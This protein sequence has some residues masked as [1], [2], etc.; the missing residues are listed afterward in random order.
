[1]KP[2]SPGH[3]MDNP[4]HQEEIKPAAMLMN[5]ERS[6]YQYQDGDNMSYSEKQALKQLPEASSWPKFS[7]TGEYD[8]MEL[9]DYI[10]GLFIDS[11]C[12]KEKQ[13]F[14]VEFKDKPRERVAEVTK[15]NNPCHNFG[16]TDHYANN[17]PKAKKKVHAIEKVPEEESLT[18]DSESDSMG[19]AIRE[20]S[21]EEKDPREEFLVEYQEETPLEIQDIQLEAGMPQDSANKNLCKHT[22]DAQ[23]F[24]V[25]STRGM[26]YI[27]WRTTKMTVYIDNAQHPLIIDSG[28]HFSIVAR[29]QL[30]N[31]FPNWEKQLLKTKLK[32]FKSASGKMNSI[33]KSIKE[34]IIPHRKYNI[35]LNPEF[36]VLDDAHIQGFL[37]GTNYQRMYGVDI[38]NSKKRKITIGTNKEMKFSLNMYQISAQDPLEELLNEFREGQLSTTLTSKQKPV[39]LKMLRKNRPAFAIGEKTLGK[40]RG[41]DIELYLDV[42]RPYTPML[43][44]PPYPA[45]L[46]TRKGIEDHI[47]E[48]LD[49]DVIRNIGQNEIL[50]I[51]TPF[52]ITWNDGKSRLCGD[53]KALN[54]YTKSYRY[55]IPRIPH[56]LGK[57]AK[58]KHIIKMDCM[59]GSHQNGVKQNSM[60]LLRII[61]HMGIYEYTRMP[62]GIKNAPSHFQRMMN[63]IFQEEELEGWVIVY[64][65]QII[66]YSETWEDH[67]KY[68]DR[69]LSKCT[70]INLKISLK[71]CNFG[72]KELLALGHKAS[73]LSLK[74]DQKKVAAVL[75]KPVPRNIKE[76]QSFLGFASYYRHHIKHFPHITH[77]LYKLCSKDLVFE[78]TKERRDAYERIKHELT[79]AP[80]LILPDFELPFKLYIDV[81]C[82]QGLGAALHQRQIVDV[83]ALE[84]LHY[85]LEGAVFEVYTDCTALKSSLNMKTTKSHTNADGLSRWALDN[86]KSNPSY[87]PE[88]TAKINIHFMEI[89]R[90]KKF[91]F[92]EWVPENGT[93]DSG[94]TDSEGTEIPILGISSSQLH[95]EFS[96]AVIKTYLKN[97]QCGILLQLL[98]QKYR[99]PELEYQLEEPWLRDYKDNMSLLIDGLIYHREKHTSAIT[100]IE[101]DHISLILQEFHDFPYMGHMSEDRTKERVA[102]TAWWP[103]WEQE[104]NE[105]ISTCE[106][107]QKAN[108]KNGS[109]YGLLQNI[110][111]PKKPWETINMYWVTGLVPGGKEKFNACLIIVDRLSKS[112]RCL[113]CHKED[114][115]MDTALLFWNNIISTCGVPR[116]IISER[117]PKFTSEL[118]T[119][120][121][122]MLGTKLAFST[123]YHPQTDG[124]AEMMIQT[125][126]D[127]LRRFCAYSMEYKDHEGYTHD[128]VTLLPAVQLAY[129]TTQNSTTGKSP[130][131]EEKR[132]NPLLPVVHLKKNLLMIHPT[133]K[134]FHDMLKKTCDTAA[135]CIA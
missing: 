1:M 99:R 43:R 55:P 5:K 28:A 107:F 133:A 119:N 118:W 71:K 46:E 126:E 53:F 20:Q 17:C 70:P 113:P 41:H 78:I 109:K 52:L 117:D 83:Q 65:D 93:P 4:Y 96:S 69:V 116:I 34:I 135:K 82:R 110:E 105:Y 61:C 10:D 59:K 32:N 77:S 26:A 7:G 45:S 63:T 100:V 76:V 103:K 49:M 81:A 13:S 128:W 124:L 120:L 132:W 58:A 37:L 123:A 16:S 21:D 35:R 112:V 22:Q 30:D 54:N 24:L 72:Q 125:M 108:R 67:V 23:T 15:K 14:R 111:E 33:G 36:V 87:D 114:I 6:P 12:F 27:H 90:R 39:L 11:S 88:V 122:Y 79:N 89:D 91:R 44:R 48:L 101:R 102:S 85:Y 86:V 80:V 130:P 115:A 106:R 75:Q 134:D 9:I 66:I 56:A 51:T 29:N 73:G 121:Y 95:N 127:I 131:Q 3:F 2:Q 62:F 18:E 47:N 40:I 104:L 92:S 42:E 50:E 129:N 8:H 31:H 94:D 97:K 68:I 64:I 25:T 19:D 60:K 84:K 38:Y 57:L 74:I 98:Q